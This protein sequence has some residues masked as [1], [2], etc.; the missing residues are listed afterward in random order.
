MCS[1]IT[2]ISDISLWKLWTSQT[3]LRD[4]VR[5]GIIS[6]IEPQH[7]QSTLQQILYAVGEKSLFLKG[8]TEVD[9]E[10]L[11]CKTLMF[12]TFEVT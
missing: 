5:V 10:Q 1:K 6:H 8:M 11:M 9:I 2:C 3:E 4:V 7:M 12:P